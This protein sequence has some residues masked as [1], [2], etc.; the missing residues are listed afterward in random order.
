MN[1]KHVLLGLVLAFGIP[2]FGCGSEAK[3][4]K[5][6][7]AESDKSEK[8]DKKKDKGEK[9]SGSATAAP[10]AA[11]G[12]GAT[13]PTAAAGSAFA[14]L[15]ADCQVAVTFDLGK[16]LAHPAFQK[17][18]APL[19]EQI[20]ATPSPK[21]EEF[22]K[23]QAFVQKTGTSPKSV[24]TVSVCVKGL[25]QPGA[26]GDWG[27]V[28]GGDFKP[29]SIV[30][31]LEEH[32]DPTDKVIEVEGK[33]AITSDKATVGQ[34]SDATIGL[35]KTLDIFKALSGSNDHAT[36]LYKM[37]T[38]KELAFAA[39][40]SLIVAKIKNDP[41]TPEPFKGLKKV[42]GFADLAANKVTMRLTV[43]SADEAT[44]L[45]ALLILM[46]DEFA[47]K[48]SSNQFG[49]GDALKSA[50]SRIEG[51]DVV[52]EATFPATSL[53]GAAKLLAEE[54]KKAKSKI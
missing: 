10:T 46:K 45:N 38:T 14:H 7:S 2:A 41:K 20:V 43:G 28:L 40:E 15:P 18:V 36:A 13:A 54:L 23:F 16:M 9:A 26:D 37:D 4:D 6:E 32:K 39:A 34:F 22:K 31:A 49:E 30:P 52:V 50:T 5:D 53:D 19:L 11:P 27:F 17:E 29:D 44:K 12:G 25:D 1:T 3:K 35:A 33:K 42:S 24:K 8:K 51:N 21:D 47:K 48:P